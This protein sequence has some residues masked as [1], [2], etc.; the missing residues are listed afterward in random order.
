MINQPEFFGLFRRH[1]VVTFHS[2]LN[3]VELFAGVVR[4]NLIQAFFHIQNLFGVDFNVRRL[5]SEPAG[6]LMNHNPRIRQGK[7]LAFGAAGQQQ[8]AH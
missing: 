8:R 5:T 4:I 1:K 2:R 7:T 3:D 6:R